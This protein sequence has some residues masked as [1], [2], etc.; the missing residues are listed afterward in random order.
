[1]LFACALLQ[2]SGERHSVRHSLFSLCGLPMTI[3]NDAALIAEY[4]RLRHELTERVRQGQKL[5][6]RL[7]ELERILPDS[8]TYPGDPPLTLHDH[9][10]SFEWPIIVEECKPLKQAVL[11][12]H[13]G[14]WWLGLDRAAV[15]MSAA[16]VQRFEI[17]K[18]PTNFYEYILLI[19]SDDRDRIA[20][21]TS[22][23]FLTGKANHWEST[24]QRS[25]HTILALAMPISPSWVI[26]VDID[27]TLV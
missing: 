24:F 9:A 4:E 6:S 2:G 11:L 22:N 18:P 19:D 17:A 8:Y 12:A 27:I 15:T 20:I 21:E 25:G 14:T 3:P 7:V 23:A 26:G 10:S 16:W 1:M 5:D 13:S